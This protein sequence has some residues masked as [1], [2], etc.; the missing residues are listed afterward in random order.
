MCRST[1]DR[2]IQTTPVR[3]NLSTLED[4]KLTELSLELSD[5]RPLP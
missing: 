3:S 4:D 1:G 2:K 5:E